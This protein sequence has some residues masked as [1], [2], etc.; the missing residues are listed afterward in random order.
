[1]RRM[2]LTIIK[3]KI[4]AGVLPQANGVS[5]RQTRYVSGV[6][7]GCD[8]TIGADDIGIQFFGAGRRRCLLHADCYVMWTEA[9]AE[10]VALSLCKICK[11]AIKGGAPRYC[12]DGFANIHVACRDKIKPHWPR[13]RQQEPGRRNAA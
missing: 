7:V 13:P 8:G 9:C 1:M 11:K 3:A 4:A 12:L 2:D 5:V 10:A 6:C